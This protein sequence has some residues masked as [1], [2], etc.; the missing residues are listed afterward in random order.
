MDQS[1]GARI[2]ELRKARGFTQRR[3]A[4]A[5]GIDFTY[6]SKIESGT[7]PYPPSTKTLK[8]LARELQVDELELLQLAQK[9][10]TGMGNIAHTEQGIRFLRQASKLKSPEDWE[11]LIAFLEEKTG[12]DKG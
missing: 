9:L 12:G 11:E 8:K 5:V 7:I 3:L 10:P 1:V 2:K 4:E 6:L